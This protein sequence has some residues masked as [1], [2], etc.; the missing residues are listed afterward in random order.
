MTHVSPP[1]TN[2]FVSDLSGHVIYGGIKPVFSPDGSWL[3]WQQ[4]VY[5]SQ[6][7]GGEKL[8]SFPVWF[9]QGDGTGL[10]QAFENAKNF[11]WSPDSRS[12]VN[13]DTDERVELPSED[14][15]RSSEIPE[16]WR[17]PKRG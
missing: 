16:T 11:S 5:Y 7:S 8:E 14:E 13:P 17:F 10:T 15:P 4:V 2:Q 3:A 12:L 1:G 9:A 6:P